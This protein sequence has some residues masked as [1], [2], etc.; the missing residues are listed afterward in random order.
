[1]SEAKVKA[2]VNDDESNQVD[3]KNLDN[4]GS[5]SDDETNSVDYWRAKAEQAEADAAKNRSIRKKLEKE[6]DSLKKTKAT[7]SSEEDY[8][9]LWQQEQ[10]A[11][12]KLVE[13][14]RRA[15]VNTAATARLTKVGVI[16]D[17]VEAALNLIDA[18]K[19]EW[20]EENGVDEVSIQA[21]V[22]QLKTKYPFMFEK[23]ISNTNVKTPASGKTIDDEN[24]IFRSDFD[25]LSPKEKALKISK[26]IKVVD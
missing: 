23:K 20:D 9:N 10:A 4:E 26:G 16:P 1:M 2:P 7:E 18:T 15:D 3:D 12:T 17:A 24:S 25:K 6:R 14:T 8:K 11:R 13:R 5:E 22:S 21:Q 19:V